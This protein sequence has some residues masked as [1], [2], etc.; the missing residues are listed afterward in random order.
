MIVLE[1]RDRVGGRCFSRSIGAG[2]QRRGQHGRDVRRADAAPDPGAHGRAG[3]RQ[4]PHLRHG[5]AAVVRERQAHAVHRVRSRRP[6][7]RSPSSSSAPSRCR[8]STRWPQTVPLDAPWTAPN[9]RGVGLDDRPDLGRAEHHHQP[10]GASCSRWPSRP[11][12]RWSPATSRS[13]TSCSTS[14]P[15]GSVEHAGRQRRPGWR[16]GLPRLGRDP[17]DRDRRSP[18]GSAQAACCSTSPVRRI[19][20]GAR[21]AYVY[22]DKATVKAKRVIVAIPPHLAGRIVYEPERPG[23][24]ATQLTQRMPIGSLIK[25][26]AVYDKPFWRD[27]GL[28]GQA[29]SDQG[30]VKV[31]FDASPASGTPGRPARVHRRRRRPPALDDSPTRRGPPR[32]CGPTCATSA[33]RPGHPRMY[34]DQVWA[35]EIY[36]GGC[37]VGLTPP[38]RADRVRA[39]RCAPRR[40]DPLGRHR[41]RDR[42][43][44][45]HGRRRAVRQA[46]RGRGPGRALTLA[47]PHGRAQV[48]S[49]HCERPRRSTPDGECS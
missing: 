14:T 40:A 36:T 35:R 43:D 19:S 12:C 8:R 13:C 25:T 32:R 34:F 33:S 28:N 41:D 37:P 24:C 46:G 49:R 38:G 4:V 42:V 21:S 45:L 44:R 2:R 23:R 1:A 18:S 11:S 48:G 7:T 15:P 26:I 10:T 17:G 30:P 22:A 39:R 47:P 3:D 16:A 9:A 27:Q 5:Q 6:A 29:N 20:Q 31:T